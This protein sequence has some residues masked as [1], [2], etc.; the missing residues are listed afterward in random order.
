MAE[1]QHAGGEH[2]ADDHD[3]GYVGPA[4]VLIGQAGDVTEVAVR[5]DLRG[6]FQPI[7]GRF[8][9]YGRVAANP[10]LAELVSGARA[11]VVLRTPVG[12]QPGELSDPDLWGRFRI[13]G[14]STPPF[15]TDV[16][17]AD[18]D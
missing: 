6:A 2:P 3:P 8:H 7:D 14:E 17:L 9:W 16:D 15:P 5:V 18:P 1:R 4:T 12:E 13:S 10:K 11:P